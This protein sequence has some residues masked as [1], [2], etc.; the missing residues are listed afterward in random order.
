[1]VIGILAELDRAGLIHK[2]ALH[3]SASSIGE[4]I[5]KYDIKNNP[6]NALPI[7]TSLIVFIRKSTF[8]VPWPVKHQNLKFWQMF[9]KTERL[10]RILNCVIKLHPVIV[11]QFKRA[12]A[13]FDKEIPSVFVETVQS[14]VLKSM[15]VQ[16]YTGWLINT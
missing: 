9:E 15:L 13:V 6:T 8:S 10:W 7:D 11:F 1:M 4:L 5:N 3:V 16:P 2:N 14:D 12:A